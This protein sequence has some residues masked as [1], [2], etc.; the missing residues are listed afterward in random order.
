[1]LEVPLVNQENKWLV[2]GQIGTNLRF[3][4]GGD[5]VRLAAAYY[6]FLHV[7]GRK[8]EIDSTLLNYTAP[9]FL[10]Y[11]KIGRAHV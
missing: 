4:D 9:A 6:D 1:M 3:N 7:T 5:H 10:R 2:G 11:G 8:N